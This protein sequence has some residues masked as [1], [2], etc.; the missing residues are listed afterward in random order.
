[1]VCVLDFMN[2][3]AGGQDV[4]CSGS[5]VGL[6]PLELENKD[7]TTCGVFLDLTNDITVGHQGPSNHRHI[8]TS[9]QQNSI[10]VYHCADI[11]IWKAMNHNNISN[12]HFVLN[13]G[14][15]DNCILVWSW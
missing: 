3:Q 10:E 4:V 11:H 1:M 6:A 2:S 9:N 14:Y 13:F 7:I 15:H 5:L 8:P 12:H